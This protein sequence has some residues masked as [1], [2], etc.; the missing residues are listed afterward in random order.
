MS[1]AH[2]LEGK[3]RLRLKDFDAGE[4]AGLKRGEAEEKTARLIEELVEL[5]ELLYAVQM[6]SVLVILQGRDT[7]GKDGTIRHVAGPL[8]S[9]SCSVAS[10]KVPTDEELAHDFLWRVHAQTPLTGN[11]K[12]FNRS[13]YEDVLV[14]RVHELAPREVWSSRYE[15]INAFERLLADSSTIILKF[16][17]HISKDE[18]KKRLLNRE[19][20]PIK[21]WKLSVGD[22]KE[23]EYWDGYTK[24][25]E[26]AINR[27][28]TK[29]AP[30]F[31]VPADKKWFRNLAVAETLRDALM[32]YRER[33]LEKLEEVGRERKKEIEGYRQ[34][35]NHSV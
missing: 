4:D 15:H 30:W 20:D 9:Q 2:R 29:H 14:V 11:I 5:Q 12:I 10:F 34:G 28:S 17:L 16:C 13:H 6:Q 18:Q 21:S 8:N 25:Y 35:H 19:T 32:P 26:D 27:C 33:W 22:W 24:A 7:S 23:R 1:Y 3:R 31:I